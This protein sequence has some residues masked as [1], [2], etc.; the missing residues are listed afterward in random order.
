[1]I[2]ESLVRISSS[3]FIVISY[4]PMLSIQNGSINEKYTDDGVHL[5]SLGS[6]IIIDKINFENV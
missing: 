3:K 5:N 1:M 6:E 2:T 4:S